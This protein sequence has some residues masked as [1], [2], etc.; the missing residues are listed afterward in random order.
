MTMNGWL[1]LLVRLA[2]LFRR[3]SNSS[4]HIIIVVMQFRFYLRVSV[5]R[6]SSGNQYISGPRPGDY[7]I[8]F[9]DELGTMDPQIEG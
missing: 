6:T 1:G 8:N 2:V 5:L 9:G 3:S 7:A 4:S